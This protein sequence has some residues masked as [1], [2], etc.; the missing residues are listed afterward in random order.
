MHDEINNRTCSIN[1]SCGC[2]MI[3]VYTRDSF[4]AALKKDMKGARHVSIHVPYVTPHGAARFSD[5]IAECTAD[6]G[7]VDVFL[8]T[9]PNWESRDSEALKPFVAAEFAT[10]QNC[11]DALKKEGAHVTLRHAIHEKAV[12]INDNVLYLGSLNALSYTGETTE[13]MLRFDKP[14]IVELIVT[15]LNL[16]GCDECCSH[17]G[18]E[19]LLT[20]PG[21][22][23][24]TPDGDGMS[25]E[26]TRFIGAMIRRR[27]RELGLQI[28]DLAKF[29]GLSS[30]AISHA[31]AGGNMLRSTAE[32]LCKALGM[33]MHPIP[34]HLVPLI[35]QYHC[36]H[37]CSD[38]PALKEYDLVPPPAISVENA[39]RLSM[40]KLNLRFYEF[41]ARTD[42][43]RIQVSR[44]AYLNRTQ[45]LCRAVG[46]VF[47]PVVAL[48]QGVVDHL[49]E[50]AQA[51][52]VRPKRKTKPRKTRKMKSAKPR[53]ATLRKKRTG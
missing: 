41:L 30:D 9:P 49:K 28:K 26:Y 48:V 34:D 1:H 14:W 6:G 46:L 37:A 36:R 27:R 45:Q 52:E 21:A 4:G 42:L 33:P 2:A 18:H 8:Q 31:E 51:P 25:S 13:I 38:N 23:T 15:L 3:Q 16:R 39:I 32:R 43:N 47:M 44:S 40:K 35:L 11:V 53:K 20:K 12:I 17:F 10:F 24:L 19:V 7:V 22:T 50:A 29:T 5:E